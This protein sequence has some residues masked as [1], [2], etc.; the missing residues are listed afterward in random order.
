[1]LEE[2]GQV[3]VKLQNEKVASLPRT[4]DLTVGGKFMNF[5]LSDLTLIFETLAYS[6]L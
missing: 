4:S 5:D 2:D 3:Y 1:M 6:K